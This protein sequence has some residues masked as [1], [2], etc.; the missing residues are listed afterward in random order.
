MSTTILISSNNYSGQT[1]SM[2]YYPSTGGTVNVGD[3]T[4][5]YYYTNDYIYGVYDIYFSGYPQTCSFN[6]P[7]PDTNY[8]LQENGFYILQEDGSKIIIT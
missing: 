3:V 7:N 8:L 2:T 6:I 4:L 5:P 1:G